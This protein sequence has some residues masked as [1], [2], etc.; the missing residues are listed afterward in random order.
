LLP[1]KMK[2]RHSQTNKAAIQVICLVSSLFP[3]RQCYPTD[4]T[5]V[6]RL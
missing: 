3:A 6:L 2:P 1:P 5:M 4:L